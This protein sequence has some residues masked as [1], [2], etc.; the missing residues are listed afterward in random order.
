MRAGDQWIGSPPICGRAKA[1]TTGALTAS[2]QKVW[3]Q[4]GVRQM[5]RR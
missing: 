2:Y 4:N 3:V 1:T 5:R